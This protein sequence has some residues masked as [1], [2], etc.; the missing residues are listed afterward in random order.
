MPKTLLEA[1]ACGL[2]VI[3]TDVK[4]INEV[5]DHRN[6]GIICNTDPDSIRVAIVTLMEDEV[7]KQKLG[8]NARK[9]IV[10]NYSLDNLAGKELELLEA[11]V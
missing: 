10:E 1:M 11:L 7:L 6:N 5:I 9:T 2:P 4:G 3:G 8:E